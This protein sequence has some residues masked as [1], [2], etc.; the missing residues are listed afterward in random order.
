MKVSVLQE[1]LHMG[2][3]IAGRA[4]VSKS[5]LPVLANILLTAD[6]DWLKLSATNLEIGIICWVGA[7]VEEPGQVTI[8]GK[9][10]ADWVAALSPNRVDM[11]L[12][13][14]TQTLGLACDRYETHIK[15][16]QAEEF[17]VMPEPEQ[18]GGIELECD[19]LKS[20]I[21]QTAFSAGTDQSRL[22]L[23]GVLIQFGEGQLTMASADGFRLSVR[24]Q[25]SLPADT[26]GQVIVP[27]RSL[28]EVQ[29]VCGQ[30]EGERVKLFLEPSGKR[31][32]FQFEDVLIFSNVIEGKF[33]EWNKIIPA[34][35]MTRTTVETP[36]LLKSVRISRLFA[37][38][39]ANLLH[40][41]MQP[42]DSDQMKTGLLTVSAVD[43]ELGNNTAVLDAIIDGEPCMISL[44]CKYMIEVLSVIDTPQVAI[45][46]CNSASPAVLKPVGDSAFTHVIM[47]MHQAGSKTEKTEL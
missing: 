44:N 41:Q 39:S 6:G 28:V 2:L 11:V 8:P 23:T 25:N 45:E 18:S 10:L 5:T 22:T 34:K 19:L 3:S 7:K 30:F 37:V 16:I 12:A 13:E 27:A 31:V 38:G 20:M 40:L 36:G 21:N 17:P 15:G 1:D 43:A 14:E 32:R 4:I 47:P 9:L 29:R 33:P 35:H 42:G 46:T 24:Q 26:E